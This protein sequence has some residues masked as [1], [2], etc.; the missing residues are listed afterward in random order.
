[1]P[2]T[3]GESRGETKTRREVLVDLYEQAEERIVGPR[4]HLLDALLVMY[5][6]LALV[7]AGASAPDTWL[8]AGTAASALILVA[9]RTLRH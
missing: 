3:R 8:M 1:M 5:V 9:L 2:T 6:A 4:M 7:V